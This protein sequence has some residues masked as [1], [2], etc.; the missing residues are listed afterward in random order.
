MTE[1]V[2]AHLHHRTP[3]NEA[4]KRL[5]PELPVVVSLHGTE[6][7]MLEA[8][9]SAITSDSRLTRAK[10]PVVQLTSPCDGRR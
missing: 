4:V 10:R 7:A 2:L 8:I 9:V 6:L 3:V 1:A 5:R